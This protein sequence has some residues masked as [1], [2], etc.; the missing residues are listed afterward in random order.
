MAKD[1]EIVIIRVI[2]SARDVTAL[3]EHGGFLE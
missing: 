1:G 2:H 3:A